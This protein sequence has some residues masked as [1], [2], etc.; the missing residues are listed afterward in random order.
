MMIISVPMAIMI[1][2]GGP[3]PGIMIGTALGEFHKPF[4]QA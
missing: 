2:S 4:L 1:S 3:M